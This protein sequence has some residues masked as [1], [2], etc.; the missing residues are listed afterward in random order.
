MTENE[1]KESVYRIMYS[2]GAGSLAPME[3]NLY[4]QQ[5]ENELFE[6]EYKQ[7]EETN[8][9]SDILNAFKTEVIYFG[10]TNG[11]HTYPVGYRHSIAFM[12][13][14]P[15]TGKDIR[16]IKE[17]PQD[18]FTILANTEL[19][20]IEE[21]PI[22]KRNKAI[23]F[24][25]L[26]VSTRL[27]MEYFKIPTYAHWGYTMVNGRPVYDPATTVES[28]FPEFAHVEIIRRILAKA[29]VQ[30]EKDVVQQYAMQQSVDNSSKP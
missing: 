18:K 7:F 27:R 10:N 12:E 19:I 1:I 17:V 25:V 21:N 15:T 11:E 29:G 4:S 24:K 26:P 30:L 5:S 22:L 9:I 28:S 20:P 16:A 3:Y 6:N 13:I 14:S 2:V 23:S 8:Q